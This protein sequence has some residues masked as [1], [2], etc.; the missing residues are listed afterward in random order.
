MTKLGMVRKKQS[1]CK[2]KKIKQQVQNYEAGEN[3]YIYLQYGLTLQV[4]WELTVRRRTMKE[5]LGSKEKDATK[6]SP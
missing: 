5:L 1:T 6:Q 2:K 4:N 3:E